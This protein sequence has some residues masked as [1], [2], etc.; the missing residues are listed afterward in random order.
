MPNGLNRTGQILQQ[1]P[2]GFQNFYEGSALDSWIQ[3]FV[4]DEFKFD[5]LPPLKDFPVA[6]QSLN[7][8][9][10]AMN[11]EPSPDA[12]KRTCKTEL[13]DSFCSAWSVY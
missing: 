9:D 4:A 6:G 5:Y 3:K 11:L 13:G 2:S 12:F 10:S 8:N 7:R 1:V